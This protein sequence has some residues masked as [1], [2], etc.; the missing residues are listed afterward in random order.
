M[1]YI[2]DSAG[3][4]S[5]GSSPPCRVDR[6]P[7]DRFEK[8]G[9]DARMRVWPTVAALASLGCS[10]SLARQPIVASCPD[11]PNPV[12]FGPV[13]GLAQKGP[14]YRARHSLDSFGGWPFDDDDKS[15]SSDGST[16]TTTRTTII[17]GFYDF[18]T[19]VL[20]G[21]TP[22]QAWEENYRPTDVVVVSRLRI[23]RS[24]FSMNISGNTAKLDRLTVNP[25]ANSFYYHLPGPTPSPEAPK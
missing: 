4:S 14:A 3:N 10:S 25:N 16:I 9:D 13:A 20:N 15:R 8:L 12:L 23:V 19:A 2:I 18:E 17:R 5:A 7:L 6:M 1:S 24:L 22:K 11:I 21:L